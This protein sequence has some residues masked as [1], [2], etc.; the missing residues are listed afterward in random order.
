VRSPH[1]HHHIGSTQ[2]HP[3]HIGTYLRTHEGDPALKVSLI[4]LTSTRSNNASQDFVPKLKD[5]L[6]RRIQKSKGISSSGEDYTTNTIILKDDRMYRHNIARFNYTTYD[7]RRAQDV[8]NP[9]TSHCN[10]MALSANDT[11]HRGHRFTYGKVLG[12]YHV[13]VIHVGSGMTDY[14]PQRMEFLWVRWY[15]PVSQVSSWESSTLDR[16]K[17]PPLNDEHSFD[18][19]DPEDVLRGCHIIPCFAKRRRHPDGL[20]VSACA[21][22]KSDWFEYYVNR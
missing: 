2:K 9:R 16:V 14:T 1:V 20:G 22:D 12:I 4:I 5:Y 3:V 21:E 18:F 19:V 6:S 15:Q 8:L 10:I 7:V 11:E 17:F 13:N